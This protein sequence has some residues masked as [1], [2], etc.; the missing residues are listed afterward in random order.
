M[1]YS[2]DGSEVINIYAEV[3]SFVIKKEVKKICSNSSTNIGKITSLSFEEGSNLETLENEVFRNSKYQSISLSNCK[4]LSRLPLWCFRDCRLLT[5]IS[6]PED[7]ILNFIDEGVFTYTSI[8]TITIPSTVEEIADCSR[9]FGAVFHR[10]E[11]LVSVIFL[12]N[13]KCTKIGQQAFWICTKLTEFVFPSLVKTISERIF[14]QCFSLSRVVILSRTIEVKY[15]PFQEI[16][17]TIKKV[18]VLSQQAKNAIK[19][20]GVSSNRVILL[21]TNRYQQSCRKPNFA[22]VIIILL[23]SSQ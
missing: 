7:G 17:S 20:T 15:K 5:S 9:S 13:S 1:Q 23:Q 3:E 14:Y 21:N 11:E 4:K 19:T 22:Y 18:Y 16:E 6:L 8:I 2:T 12:E 10:C